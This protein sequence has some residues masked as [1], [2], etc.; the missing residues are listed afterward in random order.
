V[1]LLLLP[2]IG[3]QFVSCLQRVRPIAKKTGF[4]TIL[5]G[6]EHA[7][8]D[9]RH[10]GDVYA[11]AGAPK[12]ARAPGI[13][14]R[15]LHRT[16]GRADSSGQANFH[17]QQ[18]EALRAELEQVQAAVQ[19]VCAPVPS[20]GAEVAAVPDPMRS[21]GGDLDDPSPAPDDEV[22]KWSASAGVA[23]GQ[24]VP[25]AEAAENA[26]HMDAVQAWRRLCMQMAEHSGKRGGTEYVA[27]QRDADD[28]LAALKEVATR[29][30][31]R[32]AAERAA[33]E[34]VAAEQKVA[35]E[36][37]ELERAAA[38]KEQIE[39]EQAAREA[40]EAAV[41]E[42]KLEES[43]ALET[44]AARRAA[45][46]EKSAAQAAATQRANERRTMTTPAQQRVTLQS[47]VDAMALEKDSE[48]R[49][50]VTP[51]TELTDWAAWQQQ[52]LIAQN[53]PPG[54][55]PGWDSGHRLWYYYNTV[56][57]FAQWHVPTGPAA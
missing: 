7:E 50:R 5:D 56:S 16:A 6:L 20:D 37:L 48:S 22:Q 26:G 15:T 24:G 9:E 43:L 44:E 8:H 14:S 21:E 51:N 30:A 10:Y 2:F 52:A 28:Y 42:Q 23:D 3:W 19:P 13:S 36:R 17:S 46:A 11:P 54:W 29:E 12:A 53:L 38:R 27:T 33:A 31:E 18:L 47:E 49:D 34:R 39:R 57:K 41:I 40:A 1:H 25:S 32:A 4:A 45:A 35:A 55:V